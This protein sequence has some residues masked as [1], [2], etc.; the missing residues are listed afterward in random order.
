MLTIDNLSYHVFPSIFRSMLT[1]EIAFL[2]SF[3]LLCLA[4]PQLH[5]ILPALLYFFAP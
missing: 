1:T 5:N 3:R 2:F 4:W